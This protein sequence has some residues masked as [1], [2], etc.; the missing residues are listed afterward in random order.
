MSIT[1]KEYQAFTPTTFVVPDDIVA[2]QDAYL[3]SGLVAEAGEV[4]G[5]WAKYCRADFDIDELILRTKKELGD[6]LYFTFQLANR[7]DLDVE[8]ILE[9]NRSK[10]QGRMDKGKIKGDG[11]E[12]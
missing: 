5:N 12:R 3:F 10:L 2:S 9:V 8:E 11:E 1:I 7:L 4:A 6:V